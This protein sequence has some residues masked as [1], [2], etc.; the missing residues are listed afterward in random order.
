MAKKRKKK[1]K[2][3]R[4]RPAASAPSLPAKPRTNPHIAKLNLHL[5]VPSLVLQNTGSEVLKKKGS[6]PNPPPP[7]VG[8]GEQFIR[9]RVRLGV[10][11]ACTR[12]IA[13][14]PLLCSRSFFASYRYFA[15][16]GSWHPFLC[17]PIWIQPT[18]GG[19]CSRLFM[20]QFS[21]KMV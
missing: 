21:R 17:S 14:P 20:M 10:R 13:S 8:L 5:P 18:P 15:C 11:V 4:R 16:R 19:I 12:R 6:V 1:R 9:I 3:W 7:G 2:K